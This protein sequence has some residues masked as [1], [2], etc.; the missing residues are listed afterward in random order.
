MVALLPVEFQRAEF[1]TFALDFVK[2]RDQHAARGA[3]WVID[4]LAR[5]GF[6]HL[7]HQMH[8]G[9]IGV[10]LLGGMTAVIGEFLDQELRK[11]D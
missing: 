3:G 8:H 9:A 7:H 4:P 11:G 10:K 6:E 5:F 2:C 1:S